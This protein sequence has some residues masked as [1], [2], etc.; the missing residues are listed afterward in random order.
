MEKPHHPDSANLRRG[1][2][3][4]LS[5]M[6]GATSLFEGQ[7]L[8]VLIHELRVHQTELEMQNEELRRAE[9]KAAD[10]RRRYQE[11]YDFAPVGHFTLDERGAIQEANQAGAS[12]LGRNRNELAGLSL[13][14]FLSAESGIEFELFRRRIF[15]GQKREQGVMLLVAG[16]RWVHI[17]GRIYGAGTA[18]DGR[19]SCLIALFDITDLIASEKKIILASQEW[20]S[21]FDTIPDLIA[22]IDTEHRILRVNRSMANALKLDPKETLGLKCY[23]HFHGADS[24]PANCVHSQLLADGQEHSLELFE[25]RL[26]GWFRVT[27]NPLRDEAG[28]LIG[29]VHVAHNITLAKQHE[30]EL[31]VS[32]VKYRQLHESMM[33]AFAK[34][35]LHGRIIE[36]NHVYQQMLGYTPE[37][38]ACM[39]YLDLTP[40]AWHA[41]EARLVAEQILPQGFSDVY[42]KEYIKKD[43]SLIPVEMRTFLL[44]DQKRRPEAMW[45]VVRDISER[46]RVEAALLESNEM[47]SLFMK[48]SP[49]FAFI[50]DVAPNESRVVMASEN[51]QELIGIPGSEIVGKTME[52]LFPS[53]F[54]EKITADDWGVVSDGQVLKLDEDFNGRNYTTLKFPLT[55]GNKCRLAGYTIDITERKQTEHELRKA[56]H[57][58]EAA[59]LAKS[60]FLANMSHEI[61]TP[62]NAIIGLGYLVLQTDLT[63]RQKDYLAKI[64]S[65]AEGLMILLNDLL[66]HSKIEAGKLELEEATFEIQPLLQRLLSLVGAGATAKGVRVLLTNDARTP[67]FLVGDHHR[68]EQVLLNLLGNAVKFTQAGEV[69]LAVR[70]LAEDEARITLEFSVR[71]TGIGMTSEQIG[72]IFEAFTQADGS[73]TRRYGGTGLGL[74]ICRRLVALMGGEIRVK[75]TPGQGSTFT[76][77]VGFLRGTAPAPEPELVLDRVAVTAALT[78]RRVLAVEDQPINQQVLRELLEQVGVIVS[79]ATDGKDALATVTASAGRFDAVLMDLQMPELDGYEATLLLRKQW[80]AERLPIIALTA[81]ARREERERCLNVGMNDHLVKPVNPCR[82]YACLLR[83]IRPARNQELPSP[84]ECRP[85]LTEDMSETLPGLDVLTGLTLLG[86]NRTLYRKLVIELGRTQTERFAELNADLNAGDLERAQRNAHSLKGV[87]GTVAA[88]SVFALAGE[89]ERACARGN[90]VAAGQLLPKLAERMA[91]VT[92]TAKLLAGQVADREHVTRDHDSG[93]ALALAREIAALTQEHDLTAQER[94]EELSLLLA[95]TELAAQSGI[96]AATFGRVD[97]RTAARQLEKLTDLLEQQVNEGK[98]GDGQDT[99]RCT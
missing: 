94:S 31:L 20:R 73:T 41:M 1:A 42:E 55:L 83:W 79:V 97:F 89:L 60:E 39:T 18:A 43:G 91:E 13:A 53:E 17:E 26:G 11:L 58:A 29:S 56:R 84:G 12:L 2:E 68:L 51:F 85:E 45:A 80:P 76:F 4:R 78:G 6:V 36:S 62:M 63:S 61:R 74:S 30:Q 46:K 28:G 71:D 7:D 72:L 64:T 69:D 34:V 24:P 98:S 95:G 93:A 40:P 16:D 67:D 65:A 44:Y 47:F 90:A 52:E 21:T 49:I 57:T 96:L 75:S 33:D 19:K 25:E 99:K 27:V 86:G 87:A 14:Q 23:R 37:E 70:V 50:K 38:L 9:Q 22:I 88:T 32:E 5:S 54:A 92:A 48:H 8:N 82:L 59:N 35:D 10:E 77:I 66:D 3:E 15:T 81:H